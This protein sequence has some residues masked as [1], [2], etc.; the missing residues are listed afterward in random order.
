MHKA[1]RYRIYPTE[2]QI[3]RLQAWDSAL[4]FLWSGGTVEYVPHAYSS[5]TCSECGAIDAASR[6]LQSVFDCTTCGHVEHADI[7]AAKVLKQRFETRANRSG[8]PADGT[9]PK[10]AGRSRKQITSR[11]LIIQPDMPVSSKNTESY[12]A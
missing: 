1:F 2:A 8:M 7:N 12:C 4:R 9:A 11:A 10:A 3:A 6:R 5:Q